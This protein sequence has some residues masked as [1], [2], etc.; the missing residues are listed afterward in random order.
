M[1]VEK[2]GTGRRVSQAATIGFSANLQYITARCETFFPYLT[3][4]QALLY[5]GFVGESG[6]YIYEE[7]PYYGES[8]GLTSR[9]IEGFT[10]SILKVMGI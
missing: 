9:G 10:D 3:S 7:M 4:K 5:D 1:R 6:Y 2:A 8:K